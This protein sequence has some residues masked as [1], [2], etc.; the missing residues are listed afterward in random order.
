MEFGYSHSGWGIKRIEKKR[1]GRERTRAVENK[2][3]G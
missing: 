1:E 3:S 2:M